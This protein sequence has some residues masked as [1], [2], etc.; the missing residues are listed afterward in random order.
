MKIEALRKKVAESTKYN[1]HTEALIHVAKF[2]GHTSIVDQLLSIHQRHLNYGHLT[3]EL[4]MLRDKFR[5][6]LRSMI[7]NETWK[8][9]WSAK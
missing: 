5:E 6:D 3:F 4:G 9:L 1:A 2:Y 7:N 8:Y